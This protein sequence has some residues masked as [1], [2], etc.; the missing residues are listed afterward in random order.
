MV[1]YYLLAEP[2]NM[3]NTCSETWVT[4][5]DNAESDL[6]K[7]FDYALEHERPYEPAP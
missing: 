3:G 1:E 6:S 4:H 7:G 5:L 2:R